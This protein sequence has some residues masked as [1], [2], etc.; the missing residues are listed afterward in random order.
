M[1]RRG[2]GARL[3]GRHRRDR[4]RTGRR[5]RD[6]ETQ[7]RQDMTTVTARS[8]SVALGIAFRG[9]TALLKNPAR[10]IAPMAIPLFM[11][12][13]FTGA[14]SAVGDTRGFDYYDYKAFEFVFVLY[15]GAVF[16]GVF[17]A[18]DI[19][20]DYESGIGARLMLSVPRRIAIIAGY[21]IFALVRAVVVIAVVWAVA[22]AFGMSVRGGASDV[23]ALILLALLLNL[24][25]TLY[26]AGVAL[27][28]QTTGAGTLVFIPVFML[29]FLTPVFAPRETLSGWLKPAADVN[30]LTFPME[31]GRGFLAAE[32][33]Q[34]GAAFAAAGG[35]AIAF[36]IWAVRGMRKAE[37]GP[38]AEASRGRRRHAAATTRTATP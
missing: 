10:A 25:T 4:C 27:R 32:P 15:V 34:V 5:R 12:V 29:M 7:D 28:L 31:A 1:E 33:V 16:T 22:L 2:A 23:A 14:L 13:A 24:A 17:T 36:L 8:L 9:M 3:R 18:F 11:F 6:D 30:P 21:V 26:G 19:A 20:H 37:K 38:G 35:L